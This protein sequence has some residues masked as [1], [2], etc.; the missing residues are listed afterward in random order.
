MSFWSSIGK[1]VGAIPVVGPVVNAVS[2]VF[3]KDKSS[4]PPSQQTGGEALSSALGQAVGTVGSSAL[5]YYTAQKTNEAQKEA[6]SSQMKFQERMSSTAHQR[7]VADLRAAGLNPILS[8][9]SGASSPS[10]AMPVYRDPGENITKNWTQ[11]AET[12]AR[13]ALNKELIR[14][15]KT[16]QNRNDAEAASSSAR[17]LRDGWDAEMTKMERD[18]FVRHPGQLWLRAIGPYVAQ[19]GSSGASIARLIKDN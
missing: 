7:E 1:F 5:S 17:A 6:S 14:T 2:S 16:V 18:Y 9:N 13:L 8:A 15:E 3:S 10:G 19:L 12:N 11:A 4:S